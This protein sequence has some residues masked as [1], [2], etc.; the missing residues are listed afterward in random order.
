[1]IKSASCLKNGCNIV[2]EEML[3]HGDLYVTDKLVI[4]SGIPK[5]S[6]GNFDYLKS[7]NK[8]L[9]SHATATEMVEIPQNG[10]FK[11]FIIYGLK[12]EKYLLE[13]VKTYK[14]QLVDLFK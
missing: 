7:M 4:L 14:P 5:D 10:E 12:A 2:C 13:L 1:M 3:F 6:I 8:Y 9:E 11:T